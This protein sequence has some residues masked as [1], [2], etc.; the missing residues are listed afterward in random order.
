MFFTDTENHDQFWFWKVLWC[1]YH[2]YSKRCKIYFRFNN[3]AHIFI[4]YTYIHIVIRISFWVL[5]EKFIPVVTLFP[6]FT[7]C[8][9]PS[10]IVQA[11]NW[12]WMVRYHS[13]NIVL[14]KK[15]VWLHQRS[16]DNK[17]TTDAVIRFS[18]TFLGL[19]LS[20]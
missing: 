4:N 13:I 11:L 6:A 19:T 12:N 8:S 15:N 2:I 14:N 7:I 20:L 18:L 9:L 3:F 16:D 1:I 10:I 5:C 17:I